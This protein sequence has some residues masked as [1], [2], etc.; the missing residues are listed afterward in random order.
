MNLK[1]KTKMFL[2]NSLY[3]RR[4]RQ[5]YLNIYGTNDEFFWNRY[6]KKWDK[7]NS[8]KQ[9]ECLG[10]EW[11]GEEIFLKLLIKY[12]SKDKKAIEIGCG[13]GRITY[14]AKK[15]F[16]HIYATDVSKN[17]LEKCKQNIQGKN[18]SFHKLDGFTLKEFY[19][20][21]VEFLFSHDVFVHFYPYRFILIYLK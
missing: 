14:K 2:A 7:T 4:L 18:I 19:L 5:L 12:S 17:M 3:L 11:K 15:L 16:S 21:K 8:K 6:V 9:L 10:N 20:R 13:G 1:T